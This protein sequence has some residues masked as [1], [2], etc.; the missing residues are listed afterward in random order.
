[1]AT[2]ISDVKYKSYKMLSLLELA[3]VS[4]LSLFLA[5][6]FLKSHSW[7]NIVIL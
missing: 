4:L 2:S 1:M 6:S 7:Y 5:R 3:M